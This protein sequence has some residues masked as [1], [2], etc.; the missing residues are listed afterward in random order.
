MSQPM[1][2]LVRFIA[3]LRNS[4]ARDLETKRI[5]QEL[6]NIRLKFKDPGLN[7]YQKKKYI[8]KLVYIYI[9]GYDVNIG[10]L[11]SI[12]L[13]ESTVYS[14][15]MIGYL[16]ISVLLNENSEMLSLV[17]NSLVKDLK[18]MNDYFV[19]LALACVATVGGEILVDVI[20]DEV[21]RLLIS[22]TSQDFVRKKAA[23]TMLRLYKK[24]NRCIPPTRSDRIVAL[25]DDPNLGVAIAVSSLL[26]ALIQD[27]PER[28]KLVYSKAVRR[29]QQ[30]LYER[31]ACPEDYYYYKVPAPWLFVK[32]FKILQYYPNSTD[33]T[34]QTALINVIY[35]TIEINATTS[36]NLQQ[37]NAQNAVLFEVI[38][39]AIHMDIEHSLM[40]KIVNI[41][42]QFLTGKETNIRYLALNSMSR[43]AT[44]YQSLPIGKYLI[45]VIQSLRDRDIS[46]RRKSIDLLYSICNVDNVKTIVTE[47]LHYLQTS[48]MSIRGEMV[49]RIAILVEKFATEYQW[50]VDIS[51][52]LIS[53]AGSHVSDEVW[54]RVVQIV[55]N[56]E[57]LQAYSARTVLTYLKAPTCNENM[58][59]IGGYIL[60]EYGH[61]I[62]EEPGFAPLDQFLALHDRYPSCTGFTKAMLLTT[63]IKFLNLFQEIR[64]QILQVFEFNINSLD[65]EIQQR[66]LEYSNMAKPENLQLMAVIWDEMPPFPERSS[67]LL[68]RLNKTQLGE[69]QDKKV[70]SSNESESKTNN[71]NHAL[72]APPPP[73]PSRKG[74]IITKSG[75]GTSTPSANGFTYLTSGWDK[76][77]HNL[78]ATNSGI[79]YSDSIVQ[80]SL[81]SEYRKHL[82]CLILDVK[83]ISGTLISSLSV[84][85]DNGPALP[86]G[87]ASPLKITNKSMIDSSL[88]HGR[89]TQH[90]IIIDCKAAFSFAPGQ[91][92]R[93]RLS[94][95]AGSLKTVVLA[96]PI[97]LEKFMEPANLSATDYF[98]RW[99]QIGVAMEAQKVFLCNNSNASATTDRNF[100]RVLNY[101]SVAEADPNPV[102]LVGAG[103]LYTSAS[104]NFGCLARLEPDTERKNYRITIRATDSGLAEK[105]AE[106]VV[107]MYK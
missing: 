31:S 46:V 97:R 32:L 58:V 54:Q 83:N 90:V 55:V 93:I 53:I 45:T 57:S 94:W 43:L 21:F 14:E 15:K 52:N 65:S 29:L 28:Y 6:A 69:F 64:T 66:A 24:D 87:D 38:N 76:Y 71:S 13:I 17:V 18:S 34:V 4:R 39:L 84:E 37:N 61:L 50:Y 7:G 82:G 44:R 95:V 78:L 22:P 68:G 5:N 107:E 42:G 48:D 30:L 12:N 26:I 91:G 80:V 106:G 56:N 98:A 16:A 67:A 41:L 27:E 89:T 86:Q 104:G 25:L 59:K 9:L 77:Y 70:W 3:D 8:C 10:H 63:Y 33:E 105:L 101:S 73:P 81:R 40:E 1:K 47:L 88:E 72:A 60:G 85:L 49:I 96:L 36:K 35:K 103:I 99:T 79:L 23:L 75:S 74:S 51:L 11:E 92:P 102:N 19:C 100:F 20:K 62:A 2:G